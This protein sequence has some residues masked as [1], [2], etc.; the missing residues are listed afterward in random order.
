M[1]VDED[2]DRVRAAAKA[3]VDQLGARVESF[4]ESLG[5]TSLQRRIHDAL[6]TTPHV[7]GGKLPP[8][9][10]ILDK[11]KLQVSQLGW[12]KLFLRFMILTKEWT[13]CDS[14]RDNFT[15]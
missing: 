15:P 3:A 7:R 9:Q 13:A 5:P 12:L 4:Q 6:T 11:I 14:S 8:L 10:P 2:M 1:T